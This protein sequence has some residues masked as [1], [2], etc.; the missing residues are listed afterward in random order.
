M[1]WETSK[2]FTED[3]LTWIMCLSVFVF[4][5]HSWTNSTEH[6]NLDLSTRALCLRFNLMSNLTIWL[7]IGNAKLVLFHLSQAYNN[8]N[9]SNEKR[10]T[11]IGHIFPFLNGK[12]NVDVFST[13]SSLLREKKRCINR[14]NE[15]KNI[16]NCFECNLPIE[17]KLIRRRKRKQKK[18]M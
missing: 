9:T 12:L 13:T 6:L 17:R 5:E 1:Y 15:K 4:P 8:N 18:N 14:K 2:A 11:C 7:K 16:C 10:I 3:F